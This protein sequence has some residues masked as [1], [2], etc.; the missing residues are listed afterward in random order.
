MGK[1]GIEAED[2]VV[3]APAPVRTSKAVVNWRPVGRIEDYRMFGGRFSI[4]RPPVE[5]AEVINC[6]ACHSSGYQSYTCS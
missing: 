3:D 2:P 1:V 4:L 5:Q 6:E